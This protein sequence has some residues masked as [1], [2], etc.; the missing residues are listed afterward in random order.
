M[1]A[2]GLPKGAVPTELNMF[3][4]CLTGGWLGDNLELNT[5]KLNVF[6]KRMEMHISIQCAYLAIG[7]ALTVW[8]ARTLE[9]N[10]GIFL[11]D[12]FQGN[13]ELGQAV[14][15]LLLFGFYLINVGYVTWTMSTPNPESGR[16]AIERLTDKVGGMLVVLGIT[17]FFVL[18]AFRRLR[19]GA[20]ESSGHSR[21]SQA[22]G[23]WI[24]ESAPLG[25]ALE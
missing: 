18:S 21:A 19:N 23:G 5:F 4:I 10:G 16:V 7:L 1:V 8:V 12:A 6:R 25:K 9:R 20:R 15:R 17:H 11:V 24:P 13:A 14:K 3:R 22:P 2:K